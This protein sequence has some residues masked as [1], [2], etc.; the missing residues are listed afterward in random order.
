MNVWPGLGPRMLPAFGGFPGGDSDLPL[1]LGANVIVLAVAALFAYRGYERGWKREF[2]LLIFIVIG[3]VTVVYWGATLIRVINNLYV[4]GRIAIAGRLDP[5]EIFKIA[6]GLLKSIPPL[7]SQDQTII[8]LTPSNFLTLVFLVF[9]WFGNRQGKPARKTRAEG[10][11]E[12][13]GKAAAGAIKEAPSGIVPL[14][15]LPLEWLK[16]SPGVILG[17]TNGYLIAHFLLPR[18]VPTQRTVVFVPGPEIAQ[19]LMQNLIYVVIALVL[20]LILVQFELLG[21]DKK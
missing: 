1:V 9:V 2:W 18:V 21:S 12:S 19:F 7:I 8:L 17:A 13:F 4:M 16:K 11:L 15:T 14:L 5:Q 10:F 3:Y 20:V 6:P